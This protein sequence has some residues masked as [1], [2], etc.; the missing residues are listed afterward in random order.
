MTTTTENKDKVKVIFMEPIYKKH[1]WTIPITK[2]GN[3]YMTGQDLTVD[4]KTGAT[5]LT[6]EELEKF[7]FVINPT[8]FP[9]VRDFH[10][11][12]MSL[13]ADKTMVDLILISK[14]IARTVLDYKRDP[15]SFYGYLHNATL[16][17][18]SE[19]SFYD[20]V[21]DAESFI[22]T[23]PPERYIELVLLLNNRIQNSEFYIPE[24]GVGM[25]VQRNGLLKA[26]HKYPEIVLNCSPDK[27][28]S[29]EAHIV[30]LELIFY[31]IL[32]RNRNNDI[33]Y[34]GT[35]LGNDT[36]SAIRFLNKKDNE[37]LKTRLYN[38]LQNKKGK[39][40]DGQKEE[41]DFKIGKTIP[42]TLA[43][44][45]NAINM[46]RVSVLDG[47][48]KDA[49]NAFDSIK[50][51]HAELLK[52]GHTPEFTLENAT[53]L[54]ENM[55]TG[56]ESKKLKEEL[57]RISKAEDGLGKLQRKVKHHLT[58]YV[59]EDC[60]DFWDDTEKLINYMVEKKF[61]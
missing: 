14:R 31:N 8:T 44:Y 39:I 23:W 53:S 56:N 55:K 3:N 27:D 51:I 21:F 11:Y 10:T 20:N 61:S 16:E 54:Y 24:K 22:R 25:S 52:M 34:D 29:L 18:Q 46:L 60:K 7:P 36:K 26:C 12:D 48:E 59:E 43:S 17:A 47:K 49:D 15:G 5:P 9:K 40:T 1:P 6:A 45:T 4:K 38:L 57:T 33:M 2:V 13:F 28:K 50:A 41:L 30:I 37:H 32:N 58:P 42:S 19:N 35:F